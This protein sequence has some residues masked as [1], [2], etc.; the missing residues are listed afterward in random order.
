MEFAVPPAGQRSSG[1]PP[2]RAWAAE[3]GD[4]LVSWRGLSAPLPHSSLQMHLR[5]SHLLVSLF[6]PTS[7][8]QQ[9]CVEME[10]HWVPCLESHP[11]LTC[12]PHAVCLRCSRIHDVAFWLTWQSCSVPFLPVQ[13]PRFNLAPGTVYSSPGRPFTGRSENTAKTLISG[14]SWENV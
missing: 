7:G 10:N 4:P 3:H 2:E 13:S 11:L 9:C 14:E 8:A 5:S 1:A 6:L 12:D